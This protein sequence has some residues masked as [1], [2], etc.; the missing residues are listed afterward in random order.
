MKV[1]YLAFIR[2]PTERAHGIQILKTCEALTRAG[3]DL[4]L[5]VPTRESA[6][7]EDPFSFYGITTRFSLIKVSTPDWVRFGRLGFSAS[8]IW[9][10]EQVRFLKHFWDKD[11]VIY[12]RD[13]L[14]LLQFILLGRTL[15]YEAHA[16][17]TWISTFVAHRA[18][19]VVA[20]TESLRRAYAVAGVSRQKIFIAHDAV[21]ALSVTKT[22]AELDMPEGTIVSYAGSRG[23]GKGVETIERASAALLAKTLIIADKTPTVAR[24]MLAV[25]DVVVVPNSA[26]Y[27][28]SS[29]Y[30]SPM[31]LFEALQ[32]G[33]LV[34]ASDVPAIRE[35]VDE[36]SVWFF[37]P[38]DPVSLAETVARALSDPTREGKRVRAQ[39]VANAYTWEARARVIQSALT[40][41]T[42]TH[43]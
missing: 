18:H 2:I 43:K 6:I 27:M 24:Q 38:D 36:D 8:L 28:T 23:V 25:S 9:F 14:V 20:I 15:V 30:T 13:A 29:T 26:K 34:V 12:S 39:A 22:R 33:A 1:L 16:E 5:I 31:K 21:D 17:P 7:T 10:S 37:R 11:T 42:S 41:A 40:Y 35:V 19:A 3:V 4:S 32:S